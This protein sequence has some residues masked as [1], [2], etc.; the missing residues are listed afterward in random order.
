MGL[1]AQ[2]RRR[3]RG[4]D[5]TLRARGGRAR[6]CAPRERSRAPS[7]RAQQRGDGDGD[8]VRRHR[9]HVGK[10]AL[11]HLLATARVVELHH[12]HVERVF[13]VGD[14]R[15]VEREV[16]VLADAETTEVESV[17]A[18]QRRV[19]FALAPRRLPRLPR[20]CGTRRRARVRRA[21]RVDS[22]GSSRDGRRRC[23]RTRPCGSRSRA[24][25]RR[26]RRARARRG[27]RTASC[28]WRTSRCATPRA[29][30]AS[31][32]TADACCAAAAPSVRES[33][34]TRTGSAS[35][36]IAPSIRP[37]R[38]AGARRSWPRASRRSSPRPGRSRSGPRAGRGAS[39][40][41]PCRGCR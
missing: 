5:R 19:P 20:C 21:V 1:R 23:R 6:P 18:E 15:V 35:T 38:T 32:R 12:L 25:S 33:G 4:V 16:S 8:G 29:A 14:G 13:E 28:R 34:R 22:A 39:P 31:R 3:A 7:T 24:P 37:T 26:G 9:V 30:I 36:T 2:V 10:V 41:P 40:P 17:D 27:S 11:T